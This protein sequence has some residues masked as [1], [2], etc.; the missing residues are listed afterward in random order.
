MSPPIEA[1]KSLFSDFHLDLKSSAEIFLHS[2]ITCNVVGTD[3]TMY[4]PVFAAM[5]DENG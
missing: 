3:V 5:V 1:T 2:L 4:V